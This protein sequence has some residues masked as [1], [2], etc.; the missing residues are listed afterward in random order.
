MRA[1][2][3][4][5]L[6]FL[7]W[8]IIPLGILAAIAVPNFINAMNR[9]RQKRT[10]AD[11]RTVATAIEALGTDTKKYGLVPITRVLPKGDPLRFET[12]QRVT[13][14][15]LSHSL[16]PT[17]MRKLPRFDGWGT[18]M[19]VRVDR[20]YSTY[21]VRAAGRDHAFQKQPYQF[22]TTTDFDEDILLSEGNFLQYPEGICNQ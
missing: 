4:R 8:V 13:Y 10:M 16:Q 20:D 19:E 3:V 18:E 17:Y 14:A 2:A 12:L 22:R 11:M 6:L 21:V 15:D 1:K 5:R 9:A 7:L